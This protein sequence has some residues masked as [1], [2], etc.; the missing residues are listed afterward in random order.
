MREGLIPFVGQR[1]TVRGVVRKFGVRPLFADLYGETLML[2]DVTLADGT[3]LTD[4]IWLPLGLRLA[5]LHPTPGDVL[6]LTARVAPYTKHRV[7]R[8]KNGRYHYVHATADFK[9][10]HAC[11]VRWLAHTLEQKGCTP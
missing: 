2:E 9:L 1:L 8:R 7:V 11:Q 5:A 6:E 3:P 10:S 4:H